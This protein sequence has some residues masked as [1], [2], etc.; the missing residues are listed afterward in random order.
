MTDPVAMQAKAKPSLTDRYSQTQGRVLVSGTQALI[1]LMIEQ[2]AVDRDAGLNTA[3][4]VSGY[5]GSP[6]A[7]FDT[8]IARAK[9]FLEGKVVF[10]PGLNEDLAATAVWGTQQIDLSPGARHDGVF[11]MWYGKGPGVDRSM[12]AIRHANAAGTHPHGGVLLL[13]GDDHG[14]VSSTLPHQSEHNRTTYHS[15]LPVSP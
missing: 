13:M 7:G 5:R 10:Q 1:R 14:A 3:G 12:D 8:E 4:Y 6:L 11:A 2:A 15:A 9:P